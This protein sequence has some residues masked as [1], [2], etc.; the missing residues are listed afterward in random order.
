[1]NRGII[2]TNT[3]LSYMMIFSHTLTVF[4]FVYASKHGFLT[5]AG[6]G[7]C[8]LTRAGPEMALRWCDFFFFFIAVHV[9]CSGCVCI[10]M[11]DLYR[12]DTIVSAM[13]VIIHPLCCAV[14]RADYSES[15][16]E[17]IGQAMASWLA[18]KPQ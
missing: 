11:C 7:D 10:C 8:C 14:F 12:T 3:K 5:T 13:F 4:F 15:L 6:G 16:W 9:F 18:C 1:M 17:T 2:Q